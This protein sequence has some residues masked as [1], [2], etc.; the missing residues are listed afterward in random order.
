MKRIV[1]RRTNWLFVGSRQGG[2]TAAVLI[3]FTSICRR[4]GVEPWTYLHD[5]L[6]R[7]PT[8]ASTELGEL[9][10]DR[11]QVVRAAAATSPTGAA[12]VANPGSAV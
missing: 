9:L 10:P 7:L 3:S 11:W 2:Q 4:L 5:V 8:T 6:S 1:I 12:Y